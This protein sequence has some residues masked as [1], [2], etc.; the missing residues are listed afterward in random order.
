MPHR[1]LLAGLITVVA[2]ACLFASG[3]IVKPQS[4][5]FETLAKTVC[6]PLPSCAVPQRGSISCPAAGVEALPGL[7]PPWC[8]ER[9][10]T[11]VRDRMLAFA[12]VTATDDRVK[13]AITMRFDMNLD[14]DTF[15]GHI[16]GTY[17]LDVPDRGGWE[18]MMVGTVNSASLWTYRVV[19]FGTGEFEGLMLR[20]DGE[21]KAGVGDRL[22]GRVTPT[23]E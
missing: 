9:S 22:I 16:W 2:G 14:S 17:L 21:W 1:T 23:H 3:S 10:R 5:D 4:W 12:V 8:P 20:A 6:T 7:M 11:K 15:S 18:G 13:G 19:A